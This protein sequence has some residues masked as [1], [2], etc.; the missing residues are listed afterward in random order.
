MRRSSG[1]PYS[2][3]SVAVVTAAYL[4][5]CGRALIFGTDASSNPTNGIYTPATVSY[6]NSGPTVSVNGSPITINGPMFNDIAGTSS[7]V[8]YLA[9]CGSVS[10][11]PMSNGG[12]NYSSPSATWNGDGGGTGL[13]VGTPTTQ[14][15]VTSYTIGSG[16]E[17]GSGMV[18]GGYYLAMWQ[19]QG[20]QGGS[21]TGVIATAYLTVSGGAITA[22]VPASGS[23]IAYGGGYTSSFSSSTF[24]PSGVLLNNNFILTQATLSGSNTIYTG[25]FGAG[26]SGGLVGSSFT[27]S[28]FSHSGNNGTFT[29]TAST[30]TTITVAN[31]SGVDETI[32]ASATGTAGTF[33]L[34][35][36]YGNPP[37]T[38]YTGNFGSGAANNGF[39]GDSFT[40]SGFSG[41][42]NNGT[43]IVTHS[44]AT[45]ITVANIYGAAQ[46]QYATGKNTSATGATIECNVSNYI[47]GIPVT[48]GGSGFTSA[49]TFAVTDGGSGSGAVPR[50]S[51]LAHFRRTSSPIVGRRG[52]SRPPWGRPALQ[53]MC[54]WSIRGGNSK[55]Q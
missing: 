4:S 46:N 50:P 7:R 12:Q 37:K 45:T 3:A 31:S 30:T 29:V 24:M 36:V 32:A 49:P 44:T 17:A 52:L 40:I 5:K 22:C 11:I 34:T 27:I 28:G 23:P 14:T 19:P 33:V 54:R 41:A 18:D 48:D 21:P 26:G 43:F 25:V 1:S 15:G 55:D 39:V 13:T 16:A 9:I 6:V 8:G 47:T 53:R 20:T 51:C 10:S 35:Q 2:L 42:S 38:T